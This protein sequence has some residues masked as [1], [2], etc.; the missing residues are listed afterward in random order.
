MVQTVAFAYDPIRR[1]TVEVRKLV[2]HAAGGIADPIGE[3]IAHI[4]QSLRDNAG[5]IGKVENLPGW[6]GILTNQFAILCQCR[7]GAHGK[8][9]TGSAGGFLSQHTV[10]Q[11]DAL[12]SHPHVIAAHSNRGDDIVGIFHGVYGI[13]GQPEFQLRI[14]HPG[15]MRGQTAVNPQFFPIVIHEHQFSDMEFRRFLGNALCQEHGADTAASDDCQFH[16]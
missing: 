8:G 3:V 12:L 2:Q 11:G 10:G 5:G 6:L 1:Y 14:E 16:A 9:E 7:N 13:R 4:S 15:D